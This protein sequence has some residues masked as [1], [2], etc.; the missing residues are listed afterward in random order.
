MQSRD[1]PLGQKSVEGSQH[2]P[3]SNGS[4]KVQ[5]KRTADAR[6]QGAS[7]PSKIST[8]SSA[9]SEVGSSVA[10]NGF[11]HCREGSSDDES[12]WGPKFDESASAL[13]PPTEAGLSEEQE[14]HV[15]QWMQQAVREL[16][17]REDVKETRLQDGMLA[18][19]RLERSLKK[20][21]STV[22]TSL[23]H[24]LEALGSD[25]ESDDNLFAGAL[26]ELRG[27][28][29]RTNETLSKLRG[30]NG[31]RSTRPVPEDQLRK[32]FHEGLARQQPFRPSASASQSSNASSKTP[33]SSARMSSQNTAVLDQ[34]R[35]AMSELQE[36][37][38]A[39]R[40]VMQAQASELVNLKKQLGMNG[41]VCNDHQ[42]SSRGTS[43]GGPTPAL[44]RRINGKKPWAN[45]LTPPRGRNSADQRA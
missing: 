1:L 32:A 44:Q 30:G 15:T 6:S 22:K 38:E 28:E 26:G 27:L 18:V 13:R 34:M 7:T 4:G 5:G 16:R 36:S 21:L 35:Q 2:G 41:P 39:Q 29:E 25:N 8:T 20:K 12:V 3:Q 43:P 42:A 40:S 17:Q 37:V 14:K 45:V 31:G 10:E 33:S 23:E 19:R 9:S 24:R 11:F